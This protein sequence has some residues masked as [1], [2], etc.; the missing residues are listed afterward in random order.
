MISLLLYGFGGYGIM[1]ASLL[2][3]LDQKNK[4]GVLDDNK[5]NDIPNY[6]TYLGKYDKKLYSNLKILI[7]I[8]NNDIRKSIANSISHSLHTFIHQSAYHSNTSK[9]AEGSVILLNVVIQNNSIISNNC[10]I[11][12][13][14]IND[15]DVTINEFVHIYPNSYIGSNS[16]I[17][18]NF[19]IEP[20]S[21]IP[22]FSNL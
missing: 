13:N 22:R 6:V 9:V 19:Q 12:S 11:Q 10:I 4:I 14:V 5:P 7:A 18:A 21:I 8:G 2:F 3:E 17:N 20:N 16:I 15:H 1:L